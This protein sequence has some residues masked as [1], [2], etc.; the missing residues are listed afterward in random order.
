MVGGG[1]DLG[2]EGLAASALLAFCVQS[3]N[4]VVKQILVGDAPDVL[5]ADLVFRDVGAVD[6]VVVVGRVVG[7]HVVKIAKAA[8]EKEG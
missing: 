2:E 5:E 6:H 4:H 1:H 8:V 3:T 7:V